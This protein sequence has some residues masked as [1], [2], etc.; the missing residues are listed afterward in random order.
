MIFI[1]FLFVV[2]VVFIATK[3]YYYDKGHEVGFKKANT[4]TGE[5]LSYFASWF[6]KDIHPPMVGNVIYEIGCQIQ[7]YG[8]F[9]FESVRKTVEDQGTERYHENTTKYTKPND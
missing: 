4:R 1:Y 6:N 9:S 7:R 8:H 2:C 3:W 5:N